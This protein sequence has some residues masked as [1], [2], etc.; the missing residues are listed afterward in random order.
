MCHGRDDAGLVGQPSPCRPTR[1]LQ[2]GGILERAVRKA[3]RFQKR[4]DPLHRAKFRA[5]WRQIRERQIGRSDR[6]VR[7]TPTPR[8][9]SPEQTGIT[10]AM[11][12]HDPRGRRLPCTHTRVLIPRFPTRASSWNQTSIGPANAAAQSADPNSASNIATPASALSQTEDAGRHLQKPGVLYVDVIHSSSPD[13]EDGE[14]WLADRGRVSHI[15]R[16]KPRGRPMPGTTARA[17]A[18]KSAVRAPVEHLF[19]HRKERMGLFIRTIGIER[20]RTRIG[21]ANLV[22]NIQRLMF[23]S[24]KPS[25]HESA[26]IAGKHPL[27]T[28]IAIQSAH[29]HRQIRPNTQQDP[30]KRLNPL[31][32]ACYWRCPFWLSSRFVR[33][34]ALLEGR[35]GDWRG[36]GR[37]V[38]VAVVRRLSL[39]RC[40]T[41]RRGSVSS[42]RSS[43]RTCGFPAS[44]S[45][46]RSCLRPRKAARSRGK[47]GEAHVVV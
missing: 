34:V 35:V 29:Q 22:C 31:L 15:H 27:H 28:T 32:T 7:A 5:A 9:R 2:G 17:N 44:G 12:A 40:L 26:R 16:K 41:P 13:R 8:A 18:R 33:M 24:A 46:T 37:L 4:N 25:W 10:V 42:R 30:E 36:C 47:A 20:A 11:V 19:A 39:C 23:H 6:A 45:R 21:L 43:N 38:G 14:A 3:V 1:L